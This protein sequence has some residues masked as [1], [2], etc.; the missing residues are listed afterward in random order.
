VPLLLKALLDDC[1]IS[2]RQLAALVKKPD[3]HPYAKSTMSYAVSGI[4]L[5]KQDPTFK[6]KV[7]RAVG[8]IKCVASWL[9]EREVQISHIWEQAADGTEPCGLRIEDVIAEVEMLHHETK[10]HF[11]M[12]L[13]DPFR[14]DINGP[15]DLYMSE[16]THYM[17]LS[18]RSV[19]EQGGILAVVGPIGSG[20]TTALAWFERE[21]GARSDV[22]IVRPRALSV[23]GLTTPAIEAAIIYDLTE[24]AKPTTGV[25]N[26]GRQ[27]R[28]ILKEC[29]ENHTRVVLVIDEAHDLTDDALRT[30]KRLIEVKFN[31][32]SPLGVLLIGQPELEAKVGGPHSTV[33]EVARRVSVVNI[34]GLGDET[35]AYLEHKFRRAQLDASKVFAPEA[36]TALRDALTTVGKGG[37]RVSLAHPLTVN[38]IA[39]QAMNE[40]AALGE[41]LVTAAVVDG[42][43]L[44]GEE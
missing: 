29:H 32:A 25:E 1:G 2:L 14:G 41:S 8:G 21:I 7:E 24:Y 11:G 17:R 33:P 43:K 5:P 4:R 42:L 20:K 44:G 18:M 6:R 36:F 31:H 12:G 34:R 3:G 37:A 26:R 39:T 30:L 9:A 22:R 13:A 23:R 28:Q 10:R 16:E 35:R 38:L 19:A 15:D 27:V 40:A